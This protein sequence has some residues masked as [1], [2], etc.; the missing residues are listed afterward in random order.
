[1]TSEDLRVTLSAV[2]VAICVRRRVLRFA[3]ARGVVDLRVRQTPI[4]PYD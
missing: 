1:M 3:D 2:V 4:G